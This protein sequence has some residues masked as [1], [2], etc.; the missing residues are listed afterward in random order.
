M[1][2]FGVIFAVGA[3]I[4]LAVLE[5]GRE[6]LSTAYE[7]SPEITVLIC[8]GYFYPLFLFAYSY[9]ITKEG[10]TRRFFNSQ[11]TVASTFCVSLGLIGTFLGLSSMVAAISTGMNAEGDFSTK[12]GLLL[13]SIGESLDSMALAFLTSILGVGAS[14]V[15]TVSCNYLAFYYDDHESVSKLTPASVPGNVYDGTTVTTTDAGPEAIAQS[16]SGALDMKV[17]EL[18]GDTIKD[19]N[20]V[21]DKLAS[22]FQ[23]LEQTQ[24]TL[25]GEMEVMLRSE[26]S[27]GGAVG[28]Y[29]VFERLGETFETNIEAFGQSVSSMASFS[30]RM[31]NDINLIAESLS[32]L[33]KSFKKFEYKHQEGAMQ[34]NTLLDSNTQA[35]TDLA[36]IVGDLKYLLA[37]PLNVALKG[38]IQNDEL[39]LLFMPYVN[40]SGALL[41][42]E[43]LLQW[44]DR[45]RGNVPNSSIFCREMNE[46]PE[47]MLELDKW[48]LRETVKTLSDWLRKN[49]WDKD[50]IISVNIGKYL[51][52]D[53]SLVNYFRDLLE[54]F[55]INPSNIALE[56]KDADVHASIDQVKYVF[57]SIR[58]LGGKVFVDNYGKNNSSL[59]VYQQMKVD[60]VKI[61]RS[62]VNGLID[63]TGDTTVIRSILASAR[64]LG[65]ELIVEGVEND[66]QKSKLVELGFNQF[67][68]HIFSKPVADIK[69]LL[70][71]VT[72]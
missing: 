40:Q 39:S 68:G 35:I 64:E 67:Q 1:Y 45:I 23:E 30:G 15:L 21:Q 18:L 62:V 5:A 38:A 3:V 34:F 10:V 52:S 51:L 24:K 49:F 70:M 47:L 69:G 6:F 29:E 43:V 4:A 17:F 44:N 55:V 36:S 41:G 63:T 12:V 66:I 60:K 46:Y 59:V 53:T 20:I 26:N 8:I 31:M 57:R 54:E 56:F 19:S 71:M 14:T 33:H 7:L 27:P 37:P 11:V 2:Y 42:C 25:L 28:S 50:W 32:E 72:R 61:D 16:I 65:V 48:I 9:A 22:T 58:D 13:A